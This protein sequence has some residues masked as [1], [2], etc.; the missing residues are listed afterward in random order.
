LAIA[1]EKGEGVLFSETTPHVEVYSIPKYL[2][3]PRYQTQFSDSKDYIFVEEDAIINLILNTEL[4]TI[5]V[6][7][8][9]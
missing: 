5:R 8:S 9:K 6:F 3:I 2:Q 4:H 7:K 1:H